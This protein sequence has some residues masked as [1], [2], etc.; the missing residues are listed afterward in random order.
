MA[1]NKSDDHPGPD[2]P[3]EEIP[4]VPTLFVSSTED[5]PEVSLHKLAI[6]M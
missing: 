2:E 1:S 3:M 4:R 6:F 5:M